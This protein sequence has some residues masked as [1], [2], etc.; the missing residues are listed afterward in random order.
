MLDTPSQA[1][2]PAPALAS[3]GAVVIGR[4]EGARLD[5]CLQSLSALNP[6]VVYV[7]SGSTDNSLGIANRHGVTVVNLDLSKPFTAARARNEGWRKLLEI[8]PDVK[9]IQFVDGDCQIIDGWLEAASRFLN[10][11][12][13]VGAVCGRRKERKP[14]ASIYNHL[15]DVEWNTPVGQARSIGGD[16]LVQTAALKQVSGYNDSF[17]AGEEPEMCVR[18]RA[19]GWSIHRIDQD[20]TW[21]DADM[22]HFSQWWA[23]TRRAG[24]A[25]AMGTWK[26]G[27]PPENH[28]KRETR[29]I[30]IWGILI[31]TIALLGTLFSPLSLLLFAIYPVQ[32]LRLWRK[33]NAPRP[34]LYSLFL[35]LGKCPEAL[36]LINFVADLMIGKRRGIIEYKGAKPAPQS[37]QQG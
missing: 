32:F 14:D 1:P 22:H 9:A 30:V 26:H 19:H 13:N 18:I 23:R 35:V 29:S 31:P 7:D 3:I 11:Q 5:A 37:A 34:A 17:I 27:S 36:G 16:A 33:S 2:A 24:Y 21:H 4:N 12:P 8:W 10:D 25:F 15:C 28:F 20:M 6:R